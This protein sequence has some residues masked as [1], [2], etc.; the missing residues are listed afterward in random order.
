MYIP[1]LRI[2]V[3]IPGN[4][5]ISK[6]GQTFTKASCSDLLS[7]SMLDAENHSITLD[8]IQNLYMHART[9]LV[10][11]EITGGGEGKRTLFSVKSST[12]SVADI[13]TNFNGLPF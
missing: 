1:T 4:I 10:L 11:T 5:I 13:I 7:I 12:L 8:I 3:S 6:R 9:L 2:R